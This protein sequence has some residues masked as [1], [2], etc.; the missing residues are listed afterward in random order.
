MGKYIDGG[1]RVQVG[2]RERT[3][4]KLVLPLQVE[5]FSARGQD[6]ESWT[7]SQQLSDCGRTLDNMLEVIYHEQHMTMAQPVLDPLQGQVEGTPE[8]EAR[9]LFE[10]GLASGLEQA[11][12][13]VTQ[14]SDAMTEA[15]VQIDC[16]FQ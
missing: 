4:R 5:G 15:G 6:L 1:Q 8:P 11:I 7:G 10:S 13:N 3:Q 9:R 2:E 12:V 14:T 16:W